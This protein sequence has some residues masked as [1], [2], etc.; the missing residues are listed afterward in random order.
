MIHSGGDYRICSSLPRENVM[1]WTISFAAAVAI[2]AAAVML[3]ILATPQRW[4]SEDPPTESDGLAVGSLAPAWS[5]IA[6]SGQ[7][8][9]SPPRRP[10]QLIVLADH[11][12]AAFPSVADG[13]RDLVVSDDIEV[14]LL[15][16][17][18]SLA[19]APLLAGFGLGAISVVLGSA[20]L[21]A[22]YNVRTC[23][24]LMFVDQTGR[25]RAGGLVNYSWQVARLRQRA[26]LPVATVPW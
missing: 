10:L 23:P 19:A 16:R 18:P 6:E 4:R 7:L 26:A 12:L 9:T 5:L 13:L 24:Y 2:L 1:T 25:V 11:C 3:M 21:Y 8:R 20:E 15:L 22:A 14:V 17:Q